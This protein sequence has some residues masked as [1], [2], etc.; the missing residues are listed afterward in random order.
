MLARKPGVLGIAK[1][2]RAGPAQGEPLPIERQGASPPVRRMNQKLLRREVWRSSYHSRLLRLRDHIGHLGGA[3]TVNLHHLAA[4]LGGQLF[5]LFFIAMLD[6][7]LDVQ[8][9]AP[10]I[11][12]I[13]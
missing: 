3:H 13:R 12:M 5:R 4:D 10:H 7:N 1:L 8:I 9:S 6:F 11:P 2:I